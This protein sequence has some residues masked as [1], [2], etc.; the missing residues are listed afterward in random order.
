MQMRSRCLLKVISTN[1]A[2]KVLVDFWEDWG[3]S[4]QIAPECSVEL[5]SKKGWWRLHTR[6]VW[7]E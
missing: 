1:S 6:N 7:V 3:L 5:L 4:T 2:L